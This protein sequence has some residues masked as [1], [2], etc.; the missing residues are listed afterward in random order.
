MNMNDLLKKTAT[1]A[2]LVAAVALS[3]CE[4]DGDAS[5]LPGGGNGG[6]GGGVTDVVNCQVPVAGICVLDNAGEKDG[7]VN[8]LLDPA[9][10][11]LGPIAGAVNVGALTD[12]LA[13]MLENDGDLVSL[14]TEL[15]Q[16]GQLQDGLQLLLLGNDQGN[17]GLQD[18]ISGLLLG[19]DQGNGLR[20]LFGENGLPGLVQALAQGTDS[21]CQAPLGNLC[22]IAGEGTN[23]E[24]LVDLLLTSNGV[25]GALVESLPPNATDNVVS[26]LGDLLESNGGLAD[27]VTGLAAEGQLAAG[28]QA[29]LM[30]NEGANQFGLVELLGNL[31]SGLGDIVT[32]LLGTI[33][34]LFSL[35]GK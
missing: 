8:L 22:L 33:G 15:L 24:G 12:T 17:G 1:A 3:G 20:E 10:G 4:A 5:S 7:L 21:S 19:N 14:L 16:G 29:L 2:M 18:I 31:G 25:L 26:I 32:D 9:T 28:L 23:R 30:G 35:G 13:T 11:P 6:G 27:L 34:G